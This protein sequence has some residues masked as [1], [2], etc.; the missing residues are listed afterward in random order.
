M[1]ATPSGLGIELQPQSMQLLV[2]FSSDR[3]DQVKGS[4][5]G[6]KGC[7]SAISVQSENAEQGIQHRL[8]PPGS[9]A[10]AAGQISSFLRVD[11]SKPC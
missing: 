11:K 7:F 4:L 5:P 3:L 2:G 9:F 1:V 6:L 8:L 10:D